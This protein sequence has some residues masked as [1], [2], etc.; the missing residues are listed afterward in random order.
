MRTEIQPIRLKKVAITLHDLA[1][2]GHM[3]GDLLAT[4]APDAQDS[5]RARE[6]LSRCMDDLNARFGAETVQIGPAPRTRAGY[7]GTKIAFNRIPESAEFR[8]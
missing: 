4:A 2:S 8:E 1:Q 5:R 6:T 7:V 3:T